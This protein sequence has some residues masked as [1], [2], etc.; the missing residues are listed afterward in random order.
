MVLEA[1]ISEL[2]P[3]AALSYLSVA[4]VAE[5]VTVAVLQWISDLRVN[6]RELVIISIKYSPTFHNTSQKMKFKIF[7]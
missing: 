2:L 4:V 7:N 1:A 5:A 6:E 3:T